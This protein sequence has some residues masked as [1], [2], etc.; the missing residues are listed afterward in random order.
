VSR[1]A[2][3]RAYNDAVLVPLFPLHTV[4]FP[5]APLPLRVFEPRYRAMMAE[6]LG[7]PPSVH[8]SVT[9]EPQPF[10]VARIR[11]GVEVGGRA[12][13]EVVGCLA[14]VRF[15]RLHP[16]GSLDLLAAGTRRFRIVE[17]LDDDPYPR[18]DVTLLDEPEGPRAAEAR[19]LANAALER[20]LS[21]ASRLR[22][23]EP[24]PVDLPDDPVE[25]SYAV[26]AAIALEPRDAQALLQVTTA[27]R[28]L[29]FAAQLARSEASLLETIGPP[30]PGPRS[31]AVSP[32]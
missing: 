6:L 26:A 30:V 18:V 8:P 10:G 32:N 9:Q 12:D 19:R 14:V 2:R 22:S 11:E 27:A 21:V 15:V 17:R 23:E 7:D 28:R 3:E 13:T 25:A 24:P 31:D 1:P 16:D 20:Y 4:L 5:G 29:V